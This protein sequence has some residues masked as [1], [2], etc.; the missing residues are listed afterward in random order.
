MLTITKRQGVSGGTEVVQVQ[1]ESDDGGFVPQINVYDGSE[2][3]ACVLWPGD[4]QAVTA[5]LPA[6]WDETSAPLGKATIAFP[7]DVMTALEP[8]WYDAMLSIAD[9]SADL[10][11]FRLVVEPGPG[12]AAA[13]KV[14]HSYKDLTD[15]MPSVGKYADYLND[16]SGFREVA[17]ESRRWIDAEILQRAPVGCQ[18]LYGPFGCQSWDG[19]YAYYDPYGARDQAEDPILA[20]A[21]DADKLVLTTATGRRFV[22]AA[23]YK[24][25]SVILRRAVG[26]NATNDLFTLSK[27][28]ED[29]AKKTL[30]SCIANIDVDGDGFAEYVVSLGR[31]KV[32]RA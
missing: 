10:A 17:A 13:G 3:L 1:T 28:Y 15:E 30:A 19:G 6:T 27:R 18:G 4:D 31:N 22:Q 24:T 25:L 20:A 5:T 26:M 21:L 29:M 12:T 14:Y 23:V 7:L 32:R 2:T 11:A 9:G 8:S 16:Q